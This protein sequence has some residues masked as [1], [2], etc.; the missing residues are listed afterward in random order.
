M[1]VDANGRFRYFNQ[2]E[3]LGSRF[4]I[5]GQTLSGDFPQAGELRFDQLHTLTHLLR[6]FRTD[7]GHINK[8]GN[9]FQ[10]IVYFMH[11]GAGVSARDGES[12]IP[13]QRLFGD[14]ELSR[15]LFVGW[16]GDGQRDPWASAITRFRRWCLVPC[17]LI[18]VLL[19]EIRLSVGRF[20]ADDRRKSMS[21]HNRALCP[22]F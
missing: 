1:E 17:F 18:Q 20:S 10:R 15:Q 6:V 13:L 3:R 21:R 16:V 12:P 22:A 9:C 7:P 2:I 5:K 19:R 4:A 11:D 14:L 8:V